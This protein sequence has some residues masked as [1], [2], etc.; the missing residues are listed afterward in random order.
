MVD[1]AVYGGREVVSDEQTTDGAW[2]QSVLAREGLEEWRI[3]TAADGYCWIESKT[4]QLPT[5]SSPAAFL[6]EVAHALSPDPEPLG[7]GSHYHGGRWADT[8]TSL[9]NKYLQVRNG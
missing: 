5:E 4:V 2:M 6:H 7:L 9:V 1:R 8:F 3:I